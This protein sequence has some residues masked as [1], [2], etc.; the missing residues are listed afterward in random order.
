MS[1]W[2]EICE[3]TKQKLD[4]ELQQQEIDFLKWVYERHIEERESNM[5]AK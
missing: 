1:D 4:R 5:S 3:V 2:L